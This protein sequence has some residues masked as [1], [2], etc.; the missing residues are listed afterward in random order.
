VIP[1]AAVIGS[2]TIPPEQSSSLRVIGLALVLCTGLLITLSGVV[3]AAGVD[4]S[5]DNCVGSGSEAVN[6]DFDC[7]NS[8]SY[9]LIVQFRSPVS[10]ASCAGF[11]AYVDLESPVAAP[12]SPFWHYEPQ[13]GCNSSGYT[14]SSNVG[15]LS[16]FCMGSLA[17]I[18][19][20]SGAF[21]EYTANYPGP[22]EGHFM[23]FAA[24]DQSAPVTAGVDYYAFHMRFNTTNRAFCN[25]CSEPMTAVVSSIVLSSDDGTPDVVLAGTDKF[26]DHVTINCSTPAYRDADGDGYGAASAS[27][28]ACPGTPGYVTNHNDCD[29]TDPAVHPGAPDH[30]CNGIDDDCDGAVDEDNAGCACVEHAPGLVGWWRGNGDATDAAGNANATPVGGVTYAAGRVGQAFSFNGSSYVEMPDVAALEL[31]T[32]VTVEAWVRPSSLS[33]YGLIVS[34]FGGGGNFAYDLMVE[35]GGALRA[36]ISND[37]TAYD[38]LHSTP[39]VVTVG[40]WAHVATTFSAGTWRLY[41]NGALAASRNSTMTSLYASGAAQV[42]LG[43]DT[44]GIHYFDG[45]I[46]EP[47]LYNRAL[48]ASEIRAIYNAGASG[49]CGT[50]CAQSIAGLVGWWPGEGTA[51]DRS[52]YINDGSLAGNASFAPGKVGRAF[53]FDGASYVGLPNSASLQVGS[54]LTMA[55]WIKPNDVSNNQQIISKWS[56]A[57]GDFAYEMG[58]QPG[59]A[60]RED[61]SGDGTSY[62]TTVSPGGLLSVG[63]WKHVAATFAPGVCRLYLDG[64]LVTT[65]ASSF[66]SIYPGQVGPVIGVANGGL[67]FFNGLIDEPMVFNQELSA[68]EIRSIYDAGSSGMCGLGLVNDVA[69]TSSP[70]GAFVMNAPWPNPSAR[71]TTVVF[72][73]PSAAAVR[74]EVFDV[75]G[76]RVASI[77]DAQRLREGEHQATW[78]GRDASGR[79][80]AT[81]IY[82]I[83]VTAGDALAVRRVVRI[84]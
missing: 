53:S 14:L 76:R 33:D 63:V 12:L 74:V 42:N 6:N 18:W 46:D 45:L 17:E 67:Q 54:Q 70:T 2:S 11:T 55:A 82:Q 77:L 16:N 36:D 22:G 35:P 10:L 41:V 47:A 72:R 28:V 8:R 37:G 30:T 13:G 56:L 31:S 5:W 1:K 71:A 59:G 58:I 29:D 9:T 80:A 23:I 3:R 78:D 51:G 4:V 34:K 62:N 39:G 27:D 64:N 50:G 65:H 79:R 83:R 61:V 15:D 26:S 24:G 19:H 68:E 25:G 32:Q 66:S 38:E 21:F 48:S 40:T 20:P 60:F 49:M 69:P 7:S 52:Q 75:A 81:G 84:E 43:R 73:L 57:P 44:R